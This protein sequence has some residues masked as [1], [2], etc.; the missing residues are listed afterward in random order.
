MTS[1]GRWFRCLHSC[2]GQ[3]LNLVGEV[4]LSLRVKGP[5]DSVILLICMW[6]GA[7]RS[8]A[9]SLVPLGWVGCIRR[10]NTCLQTLYL[11][12]NNIG[13]AGAA[14]IVEGLLYDD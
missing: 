14:A 4:S 9:C 5:L 8:V 2:L 11:G 12:Y 10:H 1:D 6:V 7:S 13:D 3:R